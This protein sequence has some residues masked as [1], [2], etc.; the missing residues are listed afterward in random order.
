MVLD[1]AKTC[2]A[3]Q[4]TSEPCA[5]FVRSARCRGEQPAPRHALLLSGWKQQVTLH[6]LPLP[7]SPLGHGG[8]AAAIQVL[9]ERSRSPAP[10]TPGT[11]RRP[12]KGGRPCASSSSREAAVKTA[13]PCSASRSPRCPV[14]LVPAPMACRGLPSVGRTSQ[15]LLANWHSPDDQRPPI[16]AS[17]GGAGSLTPWDP[18]P[19]P[20]SP[21]STRGGTGLGNPPSV[22]CHVQRHRHPV[23]TSKKLTE[24]EDE[25]EQSCYLDPGRGRSP[26]SAF[27]APEKESLSFA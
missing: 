5:S 24:G 6:L 12:G 26:D 9:L 18:Q 13:A 8:P 2:L 1:G 20:R 3:W 21:P 22:P 15:N 23:W 14:C 7:R 10:R 11:A 19:P 17:G 16:T 4:V 25:E 27:P